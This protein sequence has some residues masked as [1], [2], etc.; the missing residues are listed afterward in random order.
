MFPTIRPGDALCIRSCSVANVAVGDIVV[1]RTPGYLIGHRAIATGE[2]DGRPYVITRPDRSR[3]GG[4][5]A[6]FDDDLLGVVFLIERGARSVP[7]QPTKYSW[8]GRLYHDGCLAVLEAKMRA[9]SWANTLAAS[10]QEWSSYRW[11][12][13]RWYARRR[14]RVHY[15]VR[16][17]AFATLGDAVCRELEPTDFDPFEPWQGR[18]VERWTLVALV[19]DAREPCGWVTFA[20]DGTAAWR[21]VESSVRTRY[22]GSWLDDAL[23]REAESILERKRGAPQG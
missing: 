23:L 2:R 1:C 5:P 3:T 17:P 16:V 10:V 14:P 9:R 19:D 18:P 21:P 20:R 8:P 6:T 13:R 22:R 15:L 12:A 7:L 11:A 4:D